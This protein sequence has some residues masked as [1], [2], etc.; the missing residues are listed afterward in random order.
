VAQRAGIDRWLVSRLQT[1]TR[2]VGEAFARYDLSEAARLLDVFI[3]TELS[4]W[5]VRRNRARFWKGADDADKRAAFATLA[6]ALERVS[7]LLAPITPYLADW[8]WRATSGA[9]ESASVHLADWPAADAS[10]VDEELERRMAVVLRAVELGRSVRAAHDLRVRQPL[11]VAKIKAADTRDAQRLRDPEL[12]R[13]VAEELNVRRVEV[14]DRADFRTL[15]AKPDW[16]RL[17]P[18]LGARM[19]AAGAAIAKVSEAELEAFAESGRLALA[20][21]GETVTF[22]REDIVLVEKGREGYAVAGGGGL[23]LALDTRLDD[24]LV[25][26]GRAREIV[27]RVQNARKTAGL[28]VSDRIVLRLSGSEDL[29]A[30]AR[31]HE[32]LILGEVL[33]TRMEI[34][35]GAGAQEFEVDGAPLGVGVEKAG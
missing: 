32:R 5:Y 7:L 22:D 33:G 11:A 30:A 19:K 28:D 8:L 17:G 20:S 31:R 35:A 2:D 21:D 23:V 4:N 1:L 3:D 6:E 24:D 34:G 27:N 25:S 16:K 13:L 15:S 9:A 14:V 29:L 18:R 12:A 26:E 10:L